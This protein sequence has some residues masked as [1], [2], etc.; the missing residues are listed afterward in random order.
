MITYRKIGGI[1]WFAIGR[2]RISICWARSKRSI[3]AFEKHIRRKSSRPT[4][5]DML[6]LERV[7]SD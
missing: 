6:A 3:T 5:V 2:L 7:I 4:V 1:H